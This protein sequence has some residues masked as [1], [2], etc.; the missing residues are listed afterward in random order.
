MGPVAVSFSK[1]SVQTKS[2]AF[3]NG[4]I[5]SC[6]WWLSF[7]PFWIRHQISKFKCCEERL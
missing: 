6:H 3:Y 5:S 2:F 1:L 7:E 4:W